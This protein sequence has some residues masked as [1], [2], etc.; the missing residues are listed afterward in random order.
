[1]ICRDLE[2]YEPMVYKAKHTEARRYF[3]EAR[4]Q[5]TILSPTRF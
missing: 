1:M 2:Q 5:G 4:E 3:S